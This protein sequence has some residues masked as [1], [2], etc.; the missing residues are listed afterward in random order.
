MREILAHVTLRAVPVVFSVVLVACGPGSGDTEGASASSTGAATS[1]GGGTSSSG[2]GVPTSTGHGA[3]DSVGTTAAMSSSETTATTSTGTTGDDTTGGSTSTGDDTTGSPIDCAGLPQGP[4]PYTIRAGP[5]ASEDLAFDH[6]GNLVG[7]QAG[8]LFKSPFDGA[9]VLWVPGAGGFIAG[10][11]M[12]STGILVYADNDTATLFRVSPGNNFKE[13]VVGGLEYPNG[14]EVDLDGFVYVAEQS[15]ARVRRID[16]LTGE[17]TI[18]APMLNNPNGL[19][20]SPDYRTLYVGSFGGGTITAIKLKEDMTEE[21]VEPFVDFV[22]GGALDG[23]AVDACGNVYVC[24][25]GPATIWR[26]TPDGLSVLPLIEL[27]GDTG[28]IPN[29][30]WG[31]G[32]GGWDAETM[33]VLDFSQNR[34]FEVPLGIGDKP[35]GYP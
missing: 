26:I 12:T 27:G 4:L 22:G 17:F 29:M 8:S 20:F 16:P 30:Q 28:W 23:M 18:L 15:G 1:T 13:P 24:E 10:L 5:Q 9:P 14:V 34:V 7:A 35:R 11:R 2:T 19:S 21:S 25:F 33:Y 3:T 32:I 31:S 6:E